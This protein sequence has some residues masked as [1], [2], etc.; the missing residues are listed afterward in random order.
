MAEVEPAL[1][2]LSNRCFL[3]TLGLE[4]MQKFNNY[5]GLIVPGGSCDLP[6]VDKKLH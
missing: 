6:V 4:D 1:E 2:Y 5:D 3:K